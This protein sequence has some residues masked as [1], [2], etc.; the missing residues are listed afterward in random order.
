MINQRVDRL[1][2]TTTVTFSLDGD[3]PVSV[4]ADFN[5]WDPTADPLRPK[6]NGLR[7][8]RVTLPSGTDIRFRYLDGGGRYFDD[9]DADFLE[10][11]GFGG[12]NGVLHLV[13]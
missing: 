6:T 2:G 8:V 9:P 4:I 3:R 7:S 12:T 5:D 11:N 13:S 10:P 1:A